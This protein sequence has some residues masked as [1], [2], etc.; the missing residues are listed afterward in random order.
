M[1]GGF[2]V[3]GFAGGDPINFA[4]PFGLCPD[5]LSSKELEEC[6]KR[7]KEEGEE[8]RRTLAAYAVCEADI[9]QT[10]MA[11]GTTLLGIGLLERISSTFGAARRVAGTSTAPAVHALAR[12]LRS[13]VNEATL[14][15]NATALPTVMASSAQM[16]RTSPGSS[17][18]SGLIGGTYRATQ[19]WGSFAVLGQGVESMVSCR[20][21][22][23]GQ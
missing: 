2:N 22:V 12:G 15:I 11:I 10:G 13:T 21:A 5:S 6:E 14:A 17:G 19:L 8:A 23:N 20:R 4:D 9:R 7:E 3:Y 18:P 1:A 16:D